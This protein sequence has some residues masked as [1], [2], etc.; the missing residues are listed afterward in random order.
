[1]VRVGGDGGGWPREFKKIAHRHSVLQEQSWQSDSESL[2][3]HSQDC[4]PVLSVAD[5]QNINENLSFPG[6]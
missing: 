1:M 4:V 2:Q 6:F 3:R 5:E